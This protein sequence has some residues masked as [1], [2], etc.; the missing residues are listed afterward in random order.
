[1]VKP[2]KVV[3]N[4]VEYESI[5]KAADANDV[6]YAAM[7]QRIAKG[8]TGD[9]DMNFQMTNITDEVEAKVIELHNKGLMRVEIQEQLGI[10]QPTI[11]KILS[12]HNVASRNGDYGKEESTEAE[13][14]KAISLYNDGLSSSQVAK[15][16]GFSK[17]WVLNVIRGHVDDISSQTKSDI[18]PEL[19]I[20]AWQK[21]ESIEMLAA[22]LG[23]TQARVLNRGYRFKQRGVPL[24]SLRTSRGYNW[25]D[26]AELA[27][28][29]LVEETD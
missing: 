4:G 19:F 8:Y 26:L 24:K 13:R 23:E 25:D 18:S 22:D 15:K 1:M 29:M 2:K 16:L 21:A 10:T 28:L 9:D 27:A 3:W 12:L 14:Q 20:S 7:T 17:K 11:R 6:S 5:R